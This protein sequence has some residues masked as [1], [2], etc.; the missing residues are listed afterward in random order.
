MLEGEIPEVDIV[1]RS[2]MGGKFI[3]TLADINKTFLLTTVLASVLTTFLVWA[4]FSAIANERSKEIG[5]MRALGAKESHIVKL[6]LLEVLVLGLLG[7]LIGVLAGTY[8]SALLA[9]TFSL[10]KNIS[11]G[12]TGNQQTSIAF[13]G[14]LIGTAICV[15]GAMMPINRIKKMEPLLVIKEE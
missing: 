10:L 15:A 8:L 4:I 12:L 5:I 13:V 11:A 7:P 6:Y 2:E 14:L 9:G 1:A 3:N